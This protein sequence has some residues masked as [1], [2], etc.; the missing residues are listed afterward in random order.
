MRTRTAALAAMLA[1]CLPVPAHAAARPQIV[2]PA[3]D[4]VAAM[5]GSY[6]VLSALFTTGGVN[7]RAGRKTVYVPTRLVVTVTYAGPVAADSYRAQVVSFATAECRVYL[8]VYG[9]APDTYGS[10]S[11]L[12]TAFT[13][14]VKA[15]GATLAFTLP[16]SALKPYLAPGTMLT[17]LSTWTNVAEPMSGYESGD[18]IGNAVTV[19]FASS[20]GTYTIR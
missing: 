3:G 1:A 6:D 12:D 5:G 17:N 14:P 9:A 8:E 19:D 10:A 20:A 13:F 11:C 16:L 7:V 2:D 4:Q 18:L 15:T